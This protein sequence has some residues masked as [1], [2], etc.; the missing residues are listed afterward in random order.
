MNEATR[1]K[2]ALICLGLYLIEGLL[3]ALL[4]GFPIEVIVG[5]QGAIVSFYFAA[6]TIQDV[7]VARYAAP[8]PPVVN[9]K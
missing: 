6:R 2:V 9:G 3:K 8:C 4:K 1:F 5:A 7:K